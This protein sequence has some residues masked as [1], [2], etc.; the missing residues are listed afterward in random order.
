MAEVE[1]LALYWTVCGPTEVHVGREWSLFDWR[2]RC[3][4]AARVGFRG[5]GLWHADIEHQLQG[6][7]HAMGNFRWSLRSWW[8]WS[9][10]S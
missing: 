2:D 4:N 6:C 1:L 7:S 8:G 5:L 10:G 9:D 3:A